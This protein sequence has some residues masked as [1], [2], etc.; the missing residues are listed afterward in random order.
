[1]R[2]SKMITAVDAHACGEPGRVI[3]GGVVDVPGKTM[4]EKMVRAAEEGQTDLAMCQYLE[5]DGTTG[6]TR[7]PAESGRW[8][9][10][11]GDTVKR[12][13]SPERV[14]E[15]HGTLREV[16]CMMCEDRLPMEHALDRVQ[17]GEDDPECRK[18]GGVLKSATISFGQ[19]LVQRDLLRAHVAA[20][21]C[22]LMLAVGS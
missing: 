19:A 1:M 20:Q 9:A 17:D 7:R 12:L 4:F 10:I 22:D 21:S 5:F 6:K 8:A 2:F 18:C 14:I 16:M 3:T 11:E 15:I 13:D